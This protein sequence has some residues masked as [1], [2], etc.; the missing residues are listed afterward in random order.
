MSFQKM[1]LNDRMRPKG[2]NLVMVYGYSSFEMAIIEEAVK[3][4]GID[5]WLYIDQLRRS[6][7]IEDIINDV[8]NNEGVKSHID[9]D[10]VILFNATSQYELQQFLKKTSNISKTKPYIAMVTSASRKWSFEA[11]QI[12]L[13]KERM[14]I[15]KMNQK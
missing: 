5:E 13:K 1:D 7:K 14:E 3:S 11:L 12:E 9:P 4:C 2:R 6:M 15:N 10:K 8:S